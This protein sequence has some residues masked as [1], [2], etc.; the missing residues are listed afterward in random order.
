LSGLFSPLITLFLLLGFLTRLLT[1]PLLL[2]QFLTR[3]APFSA[4][5]PLHS[6]AVMDTNIFKLLSYRVFLV[7]FFVTYSAI[8]A[9]LVTTFSH[10]FGAVKTL[11][12]LL[13]N[14]VG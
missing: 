4:A 14:I 12:M 9:Y 6:H 7:E 2:T 3:S 13:Q 10:N 1:A 8:T 11:L 5:I